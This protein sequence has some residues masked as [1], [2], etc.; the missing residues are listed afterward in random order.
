MILRIIILTILIM[1]NGIFSASELAF[2][3]LDKLKL[4]N[5]IKLGNKKAIT[6]EK[7]LSNSASFLSTIQIGITLAGF[8]ASAFAAFLRASS[9]SLGFF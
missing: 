2:L 6:I 8:L 9:I 5:E 1:I 4:K 7:I 3:S